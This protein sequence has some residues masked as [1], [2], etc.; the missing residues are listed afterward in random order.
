MMANPHR[1]VV[2][3][4]APSLMPPPPTTRVDG[5]CAACG[6][7]LVATMAGLRCLPCSGQRPQAGVVVLRGLA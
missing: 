6:S 7:G 5:R 2:G 1:D 4:R 3:T